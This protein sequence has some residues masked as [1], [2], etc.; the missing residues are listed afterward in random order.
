MIEWNS[1]DDLRLVE[2]PGEG[3]GLLLA[4][5]EGC[6]PCEQVLEIVKLVKQR[7]PALRVIA[8]KLKHGGHALG[9][10]A[11]LAGERIRVFPALIGTTDGSALFRRYGIATKSGPLTVDAIDKAFER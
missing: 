7:R 3:E 1:V 10:R 11:I 5:L 9:E 4:G 8:V 6:A 2:M